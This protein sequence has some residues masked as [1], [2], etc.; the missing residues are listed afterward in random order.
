MADKIVKRGRGRPRKEKPIE[1]KLEQPNQ[2]PKKRGRP[3]KYPLTTTEEQAPK[4]RG[5][6]RKTYAQSKLDS[7]A[8]NIPLTP[9][10][11]GKHLG[12]CNHCQSGI[13]TLD[14]IKNTFSEDDR[15]DVYF[16]YHC[17]KEVKKANLLEAKSQK[18]EV[19][20]RSKKEYLEDCLKISDDARIPMAPSEIVDHDDLSGF[21]SHLEQIE[22]KSGE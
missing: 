6:P 18:D 17:Q 1:N 19:K 7:E 20:Y 8:Q 11:I 12:Y 4:K 14:I 3:R 21:V 5:R 15:P 16:C 22:E 2:P 13:C 10:K 9:P